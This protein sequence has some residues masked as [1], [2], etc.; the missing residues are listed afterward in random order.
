MKQ[1]PRRFMIKNKNKTLAKPKYTI[2][3]SVL[4]ISC[5]KHLMLL[6]VLNHASLLPDFHTGHQIELR[7]SVRG[8]CNFLG[9]LNVN[10]VPP[11]KREPIKEY[12]INDFQNRNNL[13]D[14]VVSWI[15]DTGFACSCSHDKQD[16]KE[17]IKFPKPIIL[18]GVTGDRECTKGGLINIQYINENG[19]VINIETPGYYNPDQ[20]VRL[21]SAQAH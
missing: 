20:T 21:F 16:F 1:Q 11:N 6:G 3:K 9:H 14:G 12:L 15:V 18:K 5:L 4:K 10:Q 17:I 8:C 13:I 2:N 7:K 19:D